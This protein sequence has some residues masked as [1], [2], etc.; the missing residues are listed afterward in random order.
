MKYISGVRLV[1]VGMKRVPKLFQNLTIINRLMLIF[2]RKGKTFKEI[3]R[4]FG[5]AFLFFCLLSMQ[6]VAAM[7]DD[8]DHDE[9]AKPLIDRDIEMGDYVTKPSLVGTDVPDTNRNWN[10]GFRNLV[11]GESSCKSIPV[12]WSSTLSNS[13]YNSMNMGTLVSLGYS[14]GL[15]ALR[16]LD[17][18]ML[19]NNLIT[20]SFMPATSLLGGFFKTFLNIQSAD[21]NQFKHLYNC[22]K[23]AGDLNGQKVPERLGKFLVQWDNLIEQRLQYWNK[24]VT[25]A[26]NTATAAA[27]E[28]AEVEEFFHALRI[29]YVMA[30]LPTKPK[31][32]KGMEPGS[33]REALYKFINELPEA[34]RDDIGA[35]VEQMKTNSIE[36]NTPSKIQVYLMGDA[37]T[38]KTSTVMKLSKLTGIPYCEF[39]GKDVQNSD[40]LKGSIQFDSLPDLTS[41]KDESTVEN[42]L[43]KLFMCFAKT[44]VAN[45]II[46]I[47][48]MGDIFKLMDDIVSYGFEHHLMGQRDL[49]LLF[50]P[51]VNE[52]NI[53]G[54]RR[55]E[56]DLSRVT[57]IT[58]GNYKCNWAPVA[59]RLN[60]I[61]FSALPVDNKKAI[62]QSAIQKEKEILNKHLTT[63]ISQRVADILDQSMSI[64]EEAD[65]SVPGGRISQSVVGMVSN[66]AIAQALRDGSSSG[67]LASELERFIGHLYKTFTT[68]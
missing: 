30:S 34:I 38:G 13:I 19:L 6:H 22:I 3:M 39:N 26:S 64:L 9:E 10:D 48:E 41:K 7:G 27:I 62:I 28:L 54:G 14:T 8:D 32:V 52:I 53:W 46:F 63:S 1:D 18:S 57:W 29:R 47:D 21:V 44:G 67:S 24:K 51:S 17:S 2:E 45:P 65:K 5:S 25:S 23:E 12:E 40:E 4:T 43:G 31:K 61:Q 50:D 15:M 35:I 16:G 56:M 33:D 20:M 42:L 55:F 68:G 11:Q 36:T 49:K 37:G 59:S 58:T 66:W 60:I